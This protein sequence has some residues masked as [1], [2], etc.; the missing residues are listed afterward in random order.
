[1]TPKEAQLG[2][3]QQRIK[4]WREDVAECRSRAAAAR[5]AAEAHDADAAHAAEMAARWEVVHD[6]VRFGHV[7]NLDGYKGPETGEVAW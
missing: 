4:M 7:P 5:K 6:A 1:V 2:E 3:I